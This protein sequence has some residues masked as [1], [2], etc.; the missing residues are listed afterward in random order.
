[1]KTNLTMKKQKYILLIDKQYPLTKEQ[2]EIKKKLIKKQDKNLTIKYVRKYKYS[3]QREKFIIEKFANKN[4]IVLNL[5]HIVNTFNQLTKIIDSTK[6]IS[7]I[8][9][10][11]RSDNLSFVDYKNSDYETININAISINKYQKYS[12]KIDYFLTSQRIKFSLQNKK[13]KGKAIGRKKGA[14]N[15]QSDYD[16][17]KEKIRYR[18]EKRWTK[19]QIIDDINIGSPSG[20][21]YYVKNTFKKKYFK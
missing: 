5:L 9:V 19:Q 11:L 6:Y 16:P 7:I 14:Q 4:I 17:Y 13:N 8:Y 10:S 20:L 1:M 15:K 3:Y 18:L 2:E 21:T 12:H